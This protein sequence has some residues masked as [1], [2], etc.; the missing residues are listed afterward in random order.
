MIAL[1]KELRDEPAF[2]ANNWD[3][4]EHF[5]DA[6]VMAFNKLTFPSMNCTI[7]SRDRIVPDKG[8]T[9]LGQIYIDNTGIN[10]NEQKFKNLGGLEMEVRSNPSSDAAKK[11]I[12]EVFFRNRWLVLSGI[13]GT[14]QVNETITGATSGATARVFSILSNVL[15][16]TNITGTF[17][18]AETVTGSASLATGVVV[19]SPISRWLQ[20]TE[21]ANPLPRGAHEYYFC[22]W[23]DTNRNPALS[24]NLPRLIWTNG[25]EDTTTKQGAVYSWTGGIGLITAVTGGSI[26]I[27]STLTWRSLGFTED[28]SGNAYV[29]VNGVSHP[30]PVVADLNTSTLNIASTAGIIVGNLA[31]SLIESDISPIAFDMCR[32]NKGYVFYGEWRQRDLY[33]SNAFNRDPAQSITQ[34]QAFQN[35]LVLGTSLYSG[36]GSHVYR[37]TIDTVNPPVNVQTF[38]SPSGGGGLDDGRYN[39]SAYSGAAGVLN[40]YSVLMVGEQSLI[41]DTIVGAGFV[42]G[43]II[44]GGTT[45]AIAVIVFKFVSGGTN[46]LGIALND[47]S[48][49]F[50][51]TE[52]ITDLGNGTTA[53]V[54]GSVAQNY[55]QYLK[56]GAVVNVNIGTGLGSIPINPLI[57]TAITLTD[58]LTIQF[59]NSFGHSVGSVFKLAI[60]QGGADSFKFQIDGGTPSASTP[61]TGALQ[62]LGS[63]INI[64]FINKTGHHIGDFWDIGVTQAITRA[65]DN[66]Y[67]DLPSRKPGQGYKFRLPSNF[68]TMDTQE[69]QLYINSS[70]GEWSIVTT[71]LS[72]DLLSETVLLTP[73]KQAGANK[74]LYPYLTG[75]MEND[76]VYV[77]EN[78]TLDSIGRQKL[79]E[80]PQVGYL[81]DPVKL[82]F[83]ASNFVGGRIKYFEKRLYI[84][85]PEDAIMHCFDNAK[86]YWQ[87]P[88]SFPE[89]G[90]LSIFENYLVAHSNTRNQTFTM[91]TGVTDNGQGYTVE[92]RTPY[93]SV[94]SRWTSK[95][96]N[97][98][99]TEGYITGNP[100]LIHNVYLG[101]HGC[102][103]ILDHPVEPVVCIAP[104]R[105]PFGEGAFGSHPNGS[106]LD[107]ATSYFNEIYKKYSPVMQYY[108]VSLGLSCTSKNHS[109]SILSLGLNAMYSE[110]G[111][112]SLVAP[113]NKTI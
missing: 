66:F 13:T 95:F 10:G 73:L 11:D 97:M 80:K 38:S 112:N 9:L 88:K 101:V 53:N 58:G 93:T 8:K 102:G 72:A 27:D 34:T 26:S 44:Q 2:L 90:I 57:T 74:V 31:T 40:N 30:V 5:T 110:S 42:V 62:S 75:H 43:D 108:F 29:V 82:D 33:M 21:N 111:N 49:A 98:S 107:T 99:F 103:G 48:M 113:S 63:N 17:A 79:L 106:D 15:T 56:N 41:V 89:V 65:W 104:D 16:V 32:V 84:S 91:F 45:N 46:T 86:G 19:A 76:L 6:T 22:Q 55:F 94:G 85:S 54:V 47:T 77:T 23:F 18:V 69:E 60:N 105:A 7:P 36:T 78:K 87:P 59:S 100:E 24:K 39:T 81:S 28:A 14:F 3:G 51:A 96:S 70:Y 71:E 1:P 50:Q 37:V 12:I 109:Y 25:Y 67:Y 68:W 52:S 92:M 20:I 4:Y 83:L 64:Q 61:I 35:D